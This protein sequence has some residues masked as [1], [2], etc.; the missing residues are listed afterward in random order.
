MEPFVALLQKNI[1][2]RQ[3]RNTC[4]RLRLA[5]VTWTSAPTRVGWPGGISP[6]GSHRSRRDSLLS[7][8]SCH[9]GHQA[10]VTHFQCRKSRGYPWAT[11]ASLRRETRVAS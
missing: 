2:D 11:S 4:D 10:V 3:R 1:R 9:P 5:L 6:P 8:G 7:P